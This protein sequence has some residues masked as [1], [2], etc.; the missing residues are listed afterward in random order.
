MTIS[1]GLLTVFVGFFLTGAAG[2]TTWLLRMILDTEKWKAG[3]AQV[4]TRLQ[5]Q[6]RALAEEVAVI[7]EKVGV[8]YAPRQ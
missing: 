1:D 4:L 7:K 5:D 8:W 6:Q 3:N 2:F